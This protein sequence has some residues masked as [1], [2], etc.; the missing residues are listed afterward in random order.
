MLVLFFLS[1]NKLI[2]RDDSIQAII[3]IAR[4]K[5]EALMAGPSTEGWENIS[6]AK[7]NRD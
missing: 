5:K 6:Y 2:I 4:A 3:A 7:T 1:R